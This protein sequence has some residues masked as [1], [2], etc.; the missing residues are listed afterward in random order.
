MDKQAIADRLRAHAGFLKKLRLPIAEK[1][2]IEQ[3][4]TCAV[5]LEKLAKEL[6][7]DEADHQ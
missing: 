1:E 4:L 3:A 2:A 6:E 5:S 7:D